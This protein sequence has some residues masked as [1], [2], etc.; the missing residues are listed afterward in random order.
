MALDFGTNPH[1][2]T[3]TEV[4]SQQIGNVLRMI[5]SNTTVAGGGERIINMVTI[6]QESYDTLLSTDDLDS[7]TLYLIIG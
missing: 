2:P 7:G 5:T 6:T 3:P 1:A 4:Q